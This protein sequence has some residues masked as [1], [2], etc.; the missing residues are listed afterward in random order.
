MTTERVVGQLLA[1]LDGIGQLSRVAVIGATNRM[2]LID[3]SILR[4]G[5]MGIHI[6]VGLPCVSARRRIFE[7]NLAA[8]R[9][10]A[11][12]DALLEELGAHSVGLSGAEIRQ[13]C[14][15]A[16]RMALRRSGFTE[17]AVVTPNDLH[18]ALSLAKGLDA[19]TPIHGP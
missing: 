17:A 12:W 10:L 5:R 16:K 1:E 2:D 4:P 9:D 7:L 15:H 6:E 8:A 11:S 14:D 3:P 13:I 19:R 18:E